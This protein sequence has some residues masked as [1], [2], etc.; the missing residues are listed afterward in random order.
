MGFVSNLPC[1]NS[2]SHPPSQVQHLTILTFPS[3]QRVNAPYCRV[4]FPDVSRTTCRSRGSLY[5]GTGEWKRS[6]KSYLLS[7]KK[8]TVNTYFPGLL[9][10][11]IYFVIILF[12]I[13]VI[14]KGIPTVFP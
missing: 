12:Y 1:P 4:R 9:D 13:V 10:I 11:I 2:H 5:T 7:V 3:V 8:R 6:I 14:K